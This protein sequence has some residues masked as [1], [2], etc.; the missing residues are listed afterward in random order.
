MSQQSS[1]SFPVHLS[2]SKYCHGIEW[3]GERQRDTNREETD[4]QTCKSVDDRQWRPHRRIYANGYYSEWFQIKSGVAQGCPLSPLLFL[5]CAEALKVAMAQETDFKGL[6]IGGRRVKVSQFADDTNLILRGPRDIAPAN[7]ALQRWCKATGM[8]ENISK[9]VGLAMGKYRHQRSLPAGIAWTP[10]GSWAISL[11]SP[12]GNDL[13]HD[14][15]WKGKLASVRVSSEKWIGMFKTGYFGRDLVVQAKFLG[16]MR[17][18][19]F[20]VPVS[21]ENV[22]R[23]QS[24]ADILWWS[25]EPVLNGEHDKFRRFVAKRTSIGPRSKGGLNNMDIESHITG[26]YASWIRRLLAPPTREMSSWKHVLYHIA[27]VDKEG[28]DKFPEGVGILMCPMTLSD[29]ARLLDG[30]PKR[31]KYIKACLKAHWKLQVTRRSEGAQGGAA[32][33]F[34]HNPGFKLEATQAEKRY[35]STQLDVHQ[36]GDVIDSKTME[37]RTRE[38][39][40]EWIEHYHD[41]HESVSV[42][43][44]DEFME[45]MADKMMLWISQI[46]VKV[47]EDTIEDL[48]REEEIEKGEIVMLVEPGIQDQEDKYGIYV[49]KGKYE[50]VQLDT[51]SCPHRT[52]VTIEDDTLTPLKVMTWQMGKSLRVVGPQKA[53][54]PDV[55]GWEVDGVEVTLPGL[56]IK[57]VRHLLTMRKFIKPASEEAWILRMMCEID[58]KRVWAMRAPY[59]TR[60]DQVTWLKLM[61]RNLFT[62][63][64][65]TEHTGCMCCGAYDNQL[66]YIRCGV[67]REEFWDQIINLLHKLGMSRPED[68]PLFI[69]TGQLETRVPTEGRVMRVPDELAGVMFIAHRCLYAEITGARL[70]GHTVN[71]D[72]AYNRAISMALSRTRAVAEGWRK[73]VEDG[74]M[75]GGATRI[76]AERHRNR[77][78]LTY[79]PDGQYEVHAA[80]I[81]EHEATKLRDRVRARNERASPPLRRTPTTRVD[82]RVRRMPQQVAPHATEAVA[83]MADAEPTEE[84]SADRDMSGDALTT[85]QAIRIGVP[86]Q[87]TL[88]AVRNVRRNPHYTAERLAENVVH[89]EYV[90]DILTPDW[91]K[92]LDAMCMED[93]AVYRGHW[94]TVPQRLMMLVRA[95]V[96]I[97]TGARMSHVVAVVRGDGVFH[98]Y[99]N[100]SPER[101]LGI[102]LIANTDNMANTRGG[103]LFYAVV[104]SSSPLAGQ[105]GDP[106]TTLVRSR[107]ARMRQEGPL[108]TAL[109]RTRARTE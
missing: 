45:E 85:A 87:C 103:H 84:P 25:K 92:I 14:A 77:M 108:E 43:P 24:D 60:R 29:K 37:A 94:E 88:A 18:W 99:D 104:P 34:W 102:P 53:S 57:K 54:F 15:W 9:R 2:L 86:A 39:W 78:I 81:E 26:F 70:E 72:R 40:M 16:S 109:R 93:E 89:S 75:A 56:S 33:S 44:T 101:E 106:L 107:P 49:E 28:Y 38:N 50:Q 27:F 6:E 58:W 11:G 71:L 10:E 41:A 82:P 62:T 20:S 55:K 19:F 90:G 48:G 7:K 52:G 21:K 79:E 13:D 46:P 69:L 51:L 22:N 4:I 63:G 64:H 30:I 73:W 17:Y 91:P 36:M 97:E 42:P 68:V 35:W 96:S 59:C 32:T 80:L 23:I 66:H 65:T 100:D 83:A 74:D 3:I 12:I 95:A 5:I 67:I 98:I 61:H 8:R 76:I 1:N 31:A 105:L 47:M